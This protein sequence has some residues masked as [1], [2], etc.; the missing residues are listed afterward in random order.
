MQSGIFGL[1]RLLS[2]IVLFRRYSGPLTGTRSNTDALGDREVPDNIALQD[3]E[4]RASRTEDSEGLERT[5]YATIDAGEHRAQGIQSKQICVMVAS[6]QCR[7]NLSAH[8]K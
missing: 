7:H 4:R 1:L 5:L 6:I 3:P 2:E 8:R